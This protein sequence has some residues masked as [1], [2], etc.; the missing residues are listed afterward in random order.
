MARGGREEERGEVAWGAEAAGGCVHAAAPMLGGE[1][2]WPEAADAPGLGWRP[3]AEGSR[4]RGEEGEGERFKIVRS[5]GSIS[6]NEGAEREGERS[7]RPEADGSEVEDGVIGA[8][9]ERG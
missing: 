2:R 1:G 7:I 8:E 6:W 4:L 5:A 3:E 9:G